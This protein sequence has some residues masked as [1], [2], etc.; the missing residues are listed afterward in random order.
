VRAGDLELDIEGAVRKLKARKA[1]GV[2]LQVPEGLKRHAREIARR[3]SEKGFE[4]A[5]VADPCYGACDLA[6]GIRGQ[7]GGPVRREPSL[8]EGSEARGRARGAP[9]IGCGTD[10]LLHVG[11]EPL[12]LP[13]DEGVIFVEARSRL[14]LKDVVR[15]ALPLLG[16]DVGLVTT[17]QH[18]HRL[19]EAQQA[20]RKAGKR[21][22]AGSGDG[23]VRHPG[24]ILGC[25]VSAARAVIGAVDSYLFV[26]SGTFHPIAVALGTGKKV[27]A[28]DPYSGRVTDVGKLAERV[29]RQRHGLIT[30]A[31][32]ARSFGVVVC[33]K[34]GQRRKALALRTLRALREAGRE[35]WLVEADEVEPWRFKGF[36][37]EA[38]VSTACPRLAI[39][40]CMKFDV[41]LL[42]PIEAEIAIGKRLWEG[43]ALDEMSG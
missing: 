27:I 33:S 21:S 2:V 14:P 5:L 4:V 6:Q 30:M 12:G 1:I 7:V 15:K 28:A 24:Q 31:S 38:L 42:T 10:V 41:P 23:R 40:D 32:T 22:H 25:N 20:L 17:A 37:F 11:H 3:L 43:Y 19:A 29:L 16:D 39:D 18:V 34:L 26:G 35:A 9:S 13:W 8:G 36:Q